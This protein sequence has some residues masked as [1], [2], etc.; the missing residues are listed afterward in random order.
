MNIEELRTIL[1]TEC[2]TIK[3]QSEEQ[4]SK[5]LGL[6][7]IY[8]T[9]LVAVFFATSLAHTQRQTRVPVQINTATFV[10]QPR[11]E[12]TPDINNAVIPVNLSELPEIIVVLDQSA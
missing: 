4:K 7:F 6:H 9:L 5:I 1:R 2:L 11:L 12:S 8:C 3:N 10:E